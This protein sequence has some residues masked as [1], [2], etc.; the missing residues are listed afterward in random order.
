VGWTERHVILPD[1][2]SEPIIFHKRL[3][4]GGFSNVY[5]CAIGPL[6]WVPPRAAA[7]AAADRD[8][9]DDAA[10]RPRCTNEQTSAP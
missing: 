3:G 10:V 8:D 9:G 7:A 5:R 2:Q 1:L 6:T 4:E